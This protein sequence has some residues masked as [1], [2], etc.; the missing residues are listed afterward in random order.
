MRF[1]A[2]ERARDSSSSSILLLNLALFFA[3]SYKSR[4]GLR[5]T[6]EMRTTKDGEGIRSQIAGKDQAEQVKRRSIKFDQFSE[7]LEE[8][9][10]I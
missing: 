5:L 8:M 6:T 9:D 1:C 10:E 2:A 4:I 7:D 3:P